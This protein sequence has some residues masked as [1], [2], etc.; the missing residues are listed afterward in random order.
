MHVNW[1][2]PT[3]RRLENTTIGRMNVPKIPEKTQYYIVNF[4]RNSTFNMIAH[5][6]TRTL[7]QWRVMRNTSEPELKRCA[8][9]INVFTGKIFA[10]THEIT[11]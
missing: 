9:E 5:S 11:R 10:K 7:R 1:C 4:R 6:Y 3:A 2:V 8:F